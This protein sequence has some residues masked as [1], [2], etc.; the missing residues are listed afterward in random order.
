MDGNSI[1]DTQSQVGHSSS[2]NTAL[3]SSIANGFL[4]F[5]ALFRNGRHTRF[6]DYLSSYNKLMNSTPA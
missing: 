6:Y 2:N 1:C 4:G 3:V 5:F